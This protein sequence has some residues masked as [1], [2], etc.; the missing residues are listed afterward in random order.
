MWSGHPSRCYAGY[1]SCR[2]ARKDTR[3][4]VQAFGGF[5]NRLGSVIFENALVI[6]G[7]RCRRPRSCPL[8]MRVV[9]VPI[10]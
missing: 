1:L 3:I 7:N 5:I 6:Q 9:M 8:T 4:S 2:G 10:C